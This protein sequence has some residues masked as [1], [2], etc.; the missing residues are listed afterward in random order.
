MSSNDDNIQTAAGSGQ[1]AKR[2]ID[3][4]AR[5]AGADG[6]SATAQGRVA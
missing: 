3:K 4:V 6:G 1:Y 5:A 2:H